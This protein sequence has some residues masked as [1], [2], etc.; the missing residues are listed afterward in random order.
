MSFFPSDLDRAGAILGA[1]DLCEIDTVDGP[2]R[3]MIGA[4]GVFIDVLG[5]QWY[6][7]QLASVSSLES[8][9][10]GKAPEGS[11]TLSFFQDPNAVDLVAQVRALGLDYVR[12]RDVTFFIQ[13]IGSHAEFYAPTRAPI[14]WLRRTARSLTFSASGAQDRSITLAFEAWSENRRA[15]RRI[16][17]NTEGHAKLIGQPNPSLEFIPTS[18]FEEEKLFG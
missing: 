8:A 15:A 6:G 1:L 9:I 12:D 5:R 11:I 16:V 3:F 10:G 7:S 14:Q 2:A 18:D 4:D 17:L 13:P